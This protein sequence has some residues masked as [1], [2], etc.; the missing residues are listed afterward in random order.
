VSATHNGA[1]LLELSHLIGS[2]ELDKVAD[3]I[4]TAGNPLVD[5]GELERVIF[6]MRDGVIYK[7]EVPPASAE[8]T[9]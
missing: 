8:P 9:L 7:N 2:I 4:A 3:I 1:E 6:V 5:I